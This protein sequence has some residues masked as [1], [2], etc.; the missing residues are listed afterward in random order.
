[1]LS[2]ILNTRLWAGGVTFHPRQLETNRLDESPEGTDST[3]PLGSR[4]TPKPS[5]INQKEWP[6]RLLKAG[7]DTAEIT[8][9]CPSAGTDYMTREAT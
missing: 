8:I 4:R 1:M 3:Q 7:K 9:A 5:S 2:S 6:P